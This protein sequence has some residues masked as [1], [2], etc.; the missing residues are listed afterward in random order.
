M[1]NG[2]SWGT[3]TAAAPE[4]ITGLE[5]GTWFWRKDIPGRAEIGSLFSLVATP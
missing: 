5:P 1:A 4:W 2:G 3:E